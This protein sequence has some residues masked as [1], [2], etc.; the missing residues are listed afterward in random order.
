[1]IVLTKQAVS[2]ALK[3][4]KYPGYSR[5]IVSFGLV[6]DVTVDGGNAVV[7]LQLTGGNADIARK[8]KADIEQALGHVPGLERMH[9]EVHEAAAPPASVQAG[10][11]MSRQARLPGLGRVFAVASG[12]GGVGK[13][14][15]SV[16]LACAFR[17][18]GASVG[19]LDCDIYGPRIPLMMGTR[20]PAHR[21]RG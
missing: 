8:L 6:K 13:S 16:N 7:L 14:T 5:D 21:Q 2:E 18:L 9:V 20:R 10:S 19:L 3:T 11:P 15:V 17:H 1:M 4:V 12:K